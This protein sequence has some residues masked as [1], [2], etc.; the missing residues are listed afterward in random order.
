MSIQ[1]DRL[2]LDVL[3]LETLRA[4]LHKAEPS[5]HPETPAYADLKRILRDRI[6]E[7]EST[8]RVLVAR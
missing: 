2:S 1:P 8:A 6:A 4:A 7:L 5:A 3:R